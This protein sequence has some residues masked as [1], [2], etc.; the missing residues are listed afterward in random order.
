MFT[1][2]SESISISLN[3][4]LFLFRSSFPC[5]WKFYIIW[6]TIRILTGT[7]LVLPP[8]IMAAY[9]GRACL[10]QVKL[11]PALWYFLFSLYLRKLP[12]GGSIV[13]S[14]LS[15]D[16]KDNRCLGTSSLYT[17]ILSERYQGCHIYRPLTSRRKT[18]L[19][20]QQLI[21]D[22]HVHKSTRIVTVSAVGQSV[23]QQSAT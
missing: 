21:F 12:R 20:G 6:Q 2:L 16:Q 15:Q 11:F 7:N 5:L 1:C 14:T 22:K 9:I 8:R 13:A 3:S 23:L 18:W 19:L 10:R 17:E 4:M